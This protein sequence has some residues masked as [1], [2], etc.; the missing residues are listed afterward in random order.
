MRS[1]KRGETACVR[2]H[3]GRRGGTAGG[4]C[5]QRQGPAPEALHAETEALPEGEARA[6]VRFHALHDRIYRQDVLETA[7]AQVARNDGKPGV[8]GVTIE[9]I[10]KLTR[11]AGRRWW[12]K[13]VAEGERRTVLKRCGVCL[14]THL[15]RRSQR[16]SRPPAGMT[17]RSF[18]TQ[19]L[20][21]ELLQGNARNSPIVDR[22]NPL[23]RAGCGK[24][25]RPVRG[26]ASRVV[27]LT[28]L[29]STL[30]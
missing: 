22:M 19:R 25:A 20:G 24:S 13:P 2:T 5:G 1:Q 12:G 27:Q 21:L 4:L 18:L 10:E 14:T 30:P 16:A 23:G 7:W 15:R 26:G 6:E 11:G 8:D 29:A 17:Y 3:Y 28:T 9:M